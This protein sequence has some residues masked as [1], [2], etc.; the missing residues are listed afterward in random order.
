MYLRDEM[1]NWSFFNWWMDF[2]L[3][4]A[5]SVIS[6]ISFG[7][8]GRSQSKK[9]QADKT[10]EFHVAAKGGWKFIASITEK[11]IGSPVSQRRT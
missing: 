6:L 2:K 9:N 4:L 7:N 5:R 10:I 8:D 11:D 3:K 1:F